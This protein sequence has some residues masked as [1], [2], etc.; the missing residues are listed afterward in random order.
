[1]FEEIV[2]KMG[3]NKSKWPG[4]TKMCRAT[5]V[6]PSDPNRRTW[7]D[8]ILV[9]VGR[10]ERTIK[11]T[12]GVRNSSGRWRVRVW[13]FR[14]CFPYLLGKTW[15]FVTHGKLFLYIACFFNQPEVVSQIG[16][17]SEP[18][19]FCAR[20]GNV[21]SSS[22]EGGGGRSRVSMENLPTSR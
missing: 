17:S 22:C 6:T 1:M 21:V 12:L 16:H 5:W 7:P 11:D 3:W 15:H 19:C 18:N 4:Y 8:A 10:P 2:L 13:L 20:C 14:G 9:F